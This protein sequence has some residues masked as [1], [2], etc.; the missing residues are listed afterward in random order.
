MI[1]RLLVIGSFALFAR[2]G[3]CAQPLQL[4]F[5]TPLNVDGGNTTASTTLQLQN[6]NGTPLKYTLVL[7]D[8]RWLN[9]GRDADSVAS[10]Y[11]PDNKPAGPVLIAEASAGQAFS[12]KVDISHLVD[13]G[14]SVAELQCNGTKI[15]E[16][17]VRKILG[18]PFRVSLEGNPPEKPE[19][20]LVDGLPLDLHLKNDD[21]IHY[22]LSWE[23]RIKGTSIS[24]TLIAGPNGVTK[25]T[26]AP[27]SAWFSWFQSFFKDEVADGTLLLGYHPPGSAG[28]YPSKTIPVK[29]DLSFYGP[30]TRGILP[31]IVIVVVLALGGLLSAY[32]NVDLVNRI[33]AISIRKSLGT[34]ARTIGEIGPQLNSQLRVSLFLERGRINSTLPKGVFFTPEAGGVISQS[35]TD[36]AALK[37]RVDMASDVSD[38]IQHQN[39][40][41][42]T[43]QA[44]PSLMDRATKSLSAAQDLLKKS[45]L[46]AAE[47]QK[48]QT[49]VGGVVNIL[50]D[51]GKPDEDLE[52]EIAKRVQELQKQFTPAMRQDDV[53]LT[54]GERAPIPFSLLDPD[55]AELGSQTDRDA[56]TR[57]LAVIYDLVRMRIV[58]DTMI[59][60]LRRQD[61]GA[62]ASA[63]LLLRQFKEEVSVHDLGAAIAA[64]PQQL[65][66]TEDRDL[67]R[68]NTPILMRVIF[69]EPTYNRAAAKG[70]VECAW[71]FDGDK[72]TEKGW[73]VYHYFPEAGDFQVKITFKNV[74][75]SLITHHALSH[76]VTVSAQRAEGYA[77]VWVEVQRWFAGFFVTIVG[78]FAGAKDK[79]LSFDTLGTIFAVFLLGF[80]VDIAKNVIVAN[81]KQS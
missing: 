70:L 21:P 34:I 5:Y 18:L 76:R 61:F 63:E 35:D 15:G 54:I 58:D 45:V 23:L 33:K 25:F 7:K 41:M 2:L 47:Q 75:Q 46:T 50:D 27:A 1:R 38:A 28:S 81:S 57:K 48:I 16:L 8:F 62:L 32:I 40:V 73:E 17:K 30:A 44:A 4:V 13:S 26:V 77:H 9:T 72:P 68:A 55:Q 64:S 66:V 20:R 3:N 36:T 52:K 60:F 6:P 19:I 37:V 39:L 80:S 74:D 51:I 56:N 29:A 59:D 67:V 78:L 43:G 69:N 14:D 71:S 12:L 53:F 22:P 10:F 24:G 65:Y 49:L 31:T 79:V 11:G 42:D